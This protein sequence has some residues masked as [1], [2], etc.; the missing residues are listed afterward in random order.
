VNVLTVF[1][2]MA[3]YGSSGR[4]SRKLGHSASYLYTMA[5]ADV[6]RG[7]FALQF[8]LDGGAYLYRVNRIRRLSGGVVPAVGLARHARHAEVLQPATNQGGRRGLRVE[9]RQ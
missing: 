8:A 4:V 9:S 6:D 3:E 2:L 5:K 7:E 1:R